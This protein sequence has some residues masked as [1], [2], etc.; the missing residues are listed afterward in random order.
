L[1]LA[2]FAAA[3]L[4]KM[5]TTKEMAAAPRTRSSPTSLRNVDPVD[6]PIPTLTAKTPNKTIDR[7]S[8]MLGL[9]PDGRSI[10]VKNVSLY[11][12][13]MQAFTLTSSFATL[14]AMV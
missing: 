2:F 5:A 12:D 6:A 11:I 14:S 4:F 10:P 8:G 7:I 9:L 3:S 13:S 1:P